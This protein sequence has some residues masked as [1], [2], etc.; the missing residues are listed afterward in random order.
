M[1]KQGLN[2]IHINCVKG[3]WK[4]REVS[5]LWKLPT[6]M[7]FLGHFLSFWSGCLFFCFGSGSFFSSLKG[8]ANQ[9]KNFMNRKAL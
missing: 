9:L 7:S 5:L 2:G 6:A 4:E 8:A 3:I 1:L